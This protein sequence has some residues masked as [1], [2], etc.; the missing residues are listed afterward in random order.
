MDSLINSILAVAPTGLWET[1]IIAFEGLFGSFALSIIVLTVIIKLLMSPIDFFNRRST[2]KMTKVQQKIQPQVDAI[3]RKYA[4]NKEEL[5][6]KLGE[7]YQREKLNPM[8]SCLTML[9]SFGLTLALFITLLN[10][11]NAM[12]SYKIVNQYE[13]IQIAYVQE[14]VQETYSINIH[15]VINEN[16]AKEDSDE[17]KKSVFEICKPYIDEIKNLTEKQQ[18]ANANVE[19]VYEDTQESFLW[20]KN[21]WVADN[22]FKSSIP[23]FDEYVDVAR[24]SREDANINTYKETYEQIMN[25]L[26]ETNSRANGFFILVLVAAGVAFLN[27]WLVSKKAAQKSKAMLIIIP[28]LMGI[29]TLQ[30]T[31]MFA[32]Y[33]IISQLVSI[34]L[35]PIIN[36]INDYIDKRQEAKNQPAD[37][38]KRI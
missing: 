12:A 5:N 30:Y 33:I 2:A 18:V 11:M 19:K 37:R 17:T 32:I 6:K 3:N 15:D 35:L 7:L 31:T 29:F 25:P 24:I 20:I 26:R 34:A 38:L 27:Q 8:G 14:Y 10:G 23:T 1:I 22:P 9:L 21:I 13:Q 4:N 36:K 28:V 16:D